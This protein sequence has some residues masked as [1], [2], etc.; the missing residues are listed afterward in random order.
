MIPAEP[1]P[2]A[3]APPPVQPLAE[4]LTPARVAWHLEVASK[5][6]LLEAMAELLAADSGLPAKSI[7][8][9]LT[10]R[11]RLGS[12]AIGEGVALPHGRLAELE[13]P[14]GACASLA[15]PVDFDAP[16]GRPVDLVFALLVPEAATQAHLDILARLA[17]C[18]HDDTWREALRR[19]PDTA[20]LLERLR[21][22]PVP[23]G[24]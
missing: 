11:E 22:A 14:L 10:E 13:Q 20:G 23:G 8:Q 18:F 21:Q 15:A 3:G 6:R 5:K 9:I 12:T 7:F 19:A 16:D 1:E 17:R 4:L 2:A 24:R